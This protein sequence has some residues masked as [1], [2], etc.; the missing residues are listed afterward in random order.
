MP[1]SPGAQFI[2]RLEICL[3]GINEANGPSKGAIDLLIDRNRKTLNGARGSGRLCKSPVEISQTF[4]VA[5]RGIQTDAVMRPP[6]RPAILHTSIQYDNGIFWKTLIPLQFLLKGWGDATA[7]HQCYVHS[8]SQNMQALESIEGRTERRLADSDDYYYVGIT[9]RNWL[10][11]LSEHLTEMHRG[12]RKNFHAMWRDSLGLGD[13]MFSSALRQVNLSYEQAMNWEEEAVKRI[14]YGPCGL[15]MIPGGFAG[16]R[17]LHKLGIIAR[18]NISL[19]EREQAIA[20]F[21]EKYPRKGIPN[22]FIAAL[23]QDDDF[24]ARIMEARAKTLSLDQVKRIRALAAKGITVKEIT[25]EV[26]AL[27]ELQVK[28]V[29]IGKTYTRYK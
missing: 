25:K 10:L 11:R 26:R 28:N 3:A 27:N 8:I 4:I 5:D 23:W 20:R 12:S 17:Y 19:E 15:N 18:T 24:Y 16:L 9:S 7:G 1:K 6:F 13:V 2:Q 22:P 21:V 14:A 29:I